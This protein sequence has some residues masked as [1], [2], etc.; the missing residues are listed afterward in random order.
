MLCKTV[1]VFM[2]LQVSP[3]IPPS[4]LAWLHSLVTSMCHPT[5]R[6][7]AVWPC[8]DAACS[9]PCTA[10]IGARTTPCEFCM[11]EGSDSWRILG[12]GPCAPDAR[13]RSLH[14]FGRGVPHI[15]PQT[16]GGHRLRRP[17]QR[18]DINPAGKAHSNRQWLK[19]PYSDF[20]LVGYLRKWYNISILSNLLLS[21]YLS[22][23]LPVCLPVCLSIYLSI[24]LSVCL[25]IYLSYL[26]LSYLSNILSI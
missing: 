20:G 13:H 6:A 8:A 19:I 25:S 24:Y 15:C 10:E 17:N 2:S 1:M 21:I 4:H 9:F 7:R 26:I 12:M 16:M 11:Q 22:A 23:C 5:C 18:C 3:R 14:I